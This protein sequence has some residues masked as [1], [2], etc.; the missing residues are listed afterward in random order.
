MKRQFHIRTPEG[1]GEN[2]FYESL[3]C[4]PF[5]EWESLV[6]PVRDSEAHLRVVSKL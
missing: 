6:N 3:D 2:P 4:L 1:L 5:Q